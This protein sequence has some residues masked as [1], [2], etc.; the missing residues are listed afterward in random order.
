MTIRRLMAKPAATISFSSRRGVSQ[1]HV[2]VA[3]PPHG[4]GLSRADRDGLDLIAG[5]LLEQRQQLIEQPGVLGAR[6]GRKN[7]GL[8]LRPL[9]GLRCLPA[10]SQAQEGC[11]EGR[12]GPPAQIRP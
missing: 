10:A 4:Q 5:P 9:C 3:P 11:E 12:A 8:A 1:Q 6:G 2:G 7:D